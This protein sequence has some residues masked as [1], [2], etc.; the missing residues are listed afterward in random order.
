[1]GAGAIAE[2][3]AAAVASKVDILFFCLPDAEPVAETM[4]EPTALWTTQ[5]MVCGSSTTQL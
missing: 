2:E 5:P 4:F 3:S 1:M